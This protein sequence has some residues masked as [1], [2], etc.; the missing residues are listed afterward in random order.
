MVR[1]ALDVYVRR[2]AAP[3]PA[4]A[5]AAIAAAA[6]ASAH[7]HP[8]YDDSVGL[9]AA[10]APGMRPTSR[11]ARRPLELIA[12]R[13]AFDVDMRSAEVQPAVSYRAIQAA[14]EATMSCA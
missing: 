11:V 4:D 14:W 10:P 3:A 5:A 13:D 1:G 8:F 12:L 2:F 7:L 9:A 6:E